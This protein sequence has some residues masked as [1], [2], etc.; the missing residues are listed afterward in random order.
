MNN[1]SHSKWVKN[2]LALF[3]G[4]L[5]A[6]MAAELALRLYNPFGF[7]VKGQKIIIPANERFVISNN[8]VSKLDKTIIHT[9]NSLGFRGEDPPE[10]FEDYLTIVAVGG[11]S[12]ECFYLSDNKTWPY[13]LGEKLKKQFPKLWL[14]NAGLDGHSTFGHN[15]LM[16]DYILKLKAKVILFLVGFNDIG[17]K[18]ESQPG[19]LVM[20]RSLIYKS[21]LLSL[22]INLSRYVRTIRLGMGH[23]A[24]DLMATEEI[25]IP[26]KMRKPILEGHHPALQSY[27]RR[28]KNLIRVAKENNITPVLITQPALFGYAVDNVTGRDLSKIK[29]PN[30]HAHMGGYLSGALKWDILEL[31]NDVTRKTGKQEGLFV[32]DL[33]DEMPKSSLYYYDT[34][35]FTN[36]GA[37][38]CADIIYR[39]L[40]PFLE[41][42]N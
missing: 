28:L 4:C 31:F 25:D 41:N 22:L 13:L 18:H 8:R 34:I 17:F 26:P 23:N 10:D 6:L 30:F 35:H 42:F 21:E 9:K 36:E 33:A 15:I 1:I 12:T 29:L 32:I 39:R 38:F 16:Q 40:A 19:K 20:T 3:L 5:V 27:E 11:S 14:N 37:A 7:R 2:S 24:S